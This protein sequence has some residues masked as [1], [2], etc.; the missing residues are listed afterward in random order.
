M[1][2]QLFKIADSLVESPVTSFTFSNIP[3]GY[4]DLVVK[5]SPRGT[6]AEDG[7]GIR[8]NSDSGSNYTFRVVVGQGSAASSF[9][10]TS[11]YLPIGRQSGSTDTVN[12][13]G[14]NEFYIPNY[15]LSNQKSVSVDAVMENNATV[16]RAQ[17]AAGLWSGTAAI[18]SV[19]VLPGSG[20]FATSTTA[21]L[22]GIL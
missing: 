7:M 12:T 2:L 21:T 10:G 5:V 13:F 4:T 15:T 22:Y 16:A 9:S 6:V 20:S 19:T 1:A 17:L 8:F 3:S 11:S 18:T 14:N